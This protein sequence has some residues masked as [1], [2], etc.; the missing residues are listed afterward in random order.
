M[1]KDEIMKGF[2]ELQLAVLREFLTEFCCVNGIEE[3]E[4]KTY[5]K[6]ASCPSDN[7][8]VVV[9][10]DDI[11]DIKFGVKLDI[12]TKEGIF[13]PTYSYFGEFLDL[14]DKYPKTTKLLEDINNGGRTGDTTVTSGE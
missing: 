12:E 10:A 4:L 1:S 13:L 7:S 6:V 11:R 3:K 5:L 14:K 9:N 8:I 2:V